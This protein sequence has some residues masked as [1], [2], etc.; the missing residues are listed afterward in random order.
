MRE[1]EIDVGPNLSADALKDAMYPATYDDPD[2][3]CLLQEVA[4]ALVF[5]E[6]TDSDQ[7]F[8]ID[9]DEVRIEDG[10]P[11]Q[12]NFVFTFSWER[13]SP[14]KDLR[15]NGESQR[16]ISAAYT[17]DGKLIFLVPLPRRPLNSC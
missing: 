10:V 8:D 3:V 11:T 4:Y 12:V 16:E 5:A 13:Y 17:G 1:I 14:C 7:I 6:G 2:A 15:R 9:I